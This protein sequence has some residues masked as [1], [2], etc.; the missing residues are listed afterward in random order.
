MSP[1]QKERSTVTTGAY[2][3]LATVL[4]G[5]MGPV[6]LRGLHLS[7]PM[8]AATGALLGAIAGYIVATIFLSRRTRAADQELESAVQ[9]VQREARLPAMR[10]T[11]KNR[12]L[13]VAGELDDEGEMKRA[14]RILAAVPGIETVD[15]KL[16]VVSPAGH[17]DPDEMRKSIEQSLRD[18][19][20]VDG[21]GIHVMV[22]RSRVILE[23]RVKSWAESSAAEK[24]AWDFPGIVDVE[25][26]L[27]VMPFDI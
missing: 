8:D 24:V 15:N 9:S 6:L 18:H 17:P 16:K 10:I 23:G 3:A 21:H 27:E 5:V 25:N 14:D 13:T 11:V 20:E 19:A 12:R 2:I 1:T 7:V 4:G 26:R 22:H